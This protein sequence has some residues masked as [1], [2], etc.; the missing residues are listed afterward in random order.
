VFSYSVLHQCCFCET[1]C[2]LTSLA[3]AV[4]LETGD[5]TCPYTVLRV[6]SYKHDV[7]QSVYPSERWWVVITQCNKKWKWAH[8]RIGR[9]LRY[10]Y[11]EAEVSDPRILLWKTSGALKIWS[12]LCTMAAIKTAR[13]TARMSRYL[14]ICWATCT[15]LYVLEQAHYRN[16]LWW[17]RWWCIVYDSWWVRPAR[18]H[19]CTHFLSPSF[20]RQIHA[21]CPT[22]S[23]A[24]RFAR[25]A[26]M[27]AEK[28][29]LYTR[30]RVGPQTDTTCTCRIDHS[31][32][33][34][35]SSN[36]T[37]NRGVPRTEFSFGGH[38]ARFR[39]ITGST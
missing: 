2:I 9:C 19:R 28:K 29:T 27:L 30:C 11:A 36:R 16:V 6:H 5:S 25:P 37:R 23:T 20:H 14:S 26:P 10:M 32:L 3:P 12:L 18:T 1:Q 34:Y 24:V 33:G 15:F 4:C 35:T 38:Q 13:A 7:R 17:W 21:S 22:T 8:D 31:L 39:F